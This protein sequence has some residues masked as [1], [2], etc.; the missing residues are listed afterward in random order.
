M[1]L[2]WYYSSI[3]H[4]GIQRDWT[5]YKVPCGEFLKCSLRKVWV[6]ELVFNLSWSVFQPWACSVSW[7]S[8]VL[9][10]APW[11]RV[12]WKGSFLFYLMVPFSKDA[13]VDTWDQNCR[14]HRGK[15]MSVLSVHHQLKASLGYSLGPLGADIRKHFLGVTFKLLVA[16][17]LMLSL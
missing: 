16:H 7:F 3:N 2:L 5:D 9:W 14:D 13:R 6:W 17:Q 11:P 4:Y 1:W 10:Y 8:F 15:W 12:T